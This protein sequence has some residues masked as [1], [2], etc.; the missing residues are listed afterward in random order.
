MRDR[1][2]AVGGDADVESGGGAGTTIR[3][4]A[5]R[6]SAEPPMA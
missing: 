4:H 2:G 6:C 5:R 3:G 1:L